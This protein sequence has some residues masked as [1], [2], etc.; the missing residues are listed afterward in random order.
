MPFA[1]CLISLPGTGPLRARLL[2]LYDVHD[3]AILL[4]AKHRTTNNK[5]ATFAG[6]WVRWLPARAKHSLRFDEL[7]HKYLMKYTTRSVR[8]GPNLLH[9]RP[10]YSQQNCISTLRPKR[11]VEQP[12]AAM[13]ARMLRT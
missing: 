8:A 13:A 4:L 2:R 3:D 9:E 11:G 10:G 6:R 12:R 7:L 1:F 5:L